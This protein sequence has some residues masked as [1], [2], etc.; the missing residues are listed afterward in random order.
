MSNGQ[1]QDGRHFI[2][3]NANIVMKY[4]LIGLEW[5]FLVSKCMFNNSRNS[6]KTTKNLNGNYLMVKSKMAAILSE[7]KQI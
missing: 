3:K 5:W 4:V 7:R 1:I 6:I 2:D